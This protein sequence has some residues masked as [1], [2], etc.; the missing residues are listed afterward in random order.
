MYIDHNDIDQYPYYGTFYRGG[1]DEDLPLDEQVEENKVIF[2]T[3]CDITESSHNNNSNF[4]YSSYTIYFPFD[5]ECDDI[6][7]KN[8][9]LFVGNMYGLQINGI[10]IG[11]FPTQLN[12]CTVYIKDNDI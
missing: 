12:G 2:E 7:V 5:K 1:V 9:D 11:V 4:I 10:V 8:G 3:K 6:S